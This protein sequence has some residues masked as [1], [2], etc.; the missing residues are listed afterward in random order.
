M[1][2][3]IE[4]VPLGFEHQVDARGEF[5]PGAHRR[6]L[7]R[8]PNQERPAYQVYEDV[9]EG[10][11]ISPVLAGEAELKSWL[12]Q[13]GYS[14]R[15]IENFVRLGSAPSLIANNGEL[16]DGIAACSDLAPEDVEAI[17]EAAKP[18]PRRRR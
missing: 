13:Q 16:I 2:R 6:A 9:T 14:A 15:A 8:L 18:R 4:R 5:V 11:P 1:G 7:S 3:Y 17:L 10:T 12:G